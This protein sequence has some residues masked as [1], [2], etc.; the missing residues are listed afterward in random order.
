MHSLARQKC[1]EGRRSCR[2][3]GPR[4]LLINCWRYCSFC[5]QVRREKTTP[6]VAFRQPV[7]AI[8]ENESG[9]NATTD[10]TPWFSL[11]T[12]NCCCCSF[13]CSKRQAIIIIIASIP[14]THSVV[15]LNQRC[16]Q[17][18]GGQHV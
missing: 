13:D 7:Y 2:P 14:R 10:R 16:R 6:R 11:I 1:K 12:N 15:I 4:I 18:L 8:H 9:D 5:E 3:S 17:S